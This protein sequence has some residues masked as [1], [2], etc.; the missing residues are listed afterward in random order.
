[1]LPYTCNVSNCQ[2]CSSSNPLICTQ[3]AS[4]YYLADSSNLTCSQIQCLDTQYYDSSTL[5]CTCPYGTFLINNKCVYCSIEKCVACNSGGCTDCKT[6]YYVDQGGCTRCSSNCFNCTSGSSC[7]ECDYGYSLQ[8]SGACKK[9]DDRY[10]STIVG[11]SSAKAICSGGC[12]EC[13]YFQG[14]IYCTVA[15]DGYAIDP[16]GT[17]IKCSD[18]CLTCANTDYTICTSCYGSSVLISGICA[19]CTDPYALTCPSNIKYSTSCLIGYS[20]INGVCRKCATNCQSCGQAGAGKCDDGGCGSGFVKIETT[21]NCTKC[22]SSC[23]TCSTNNP[24]TCLTC[25]NSNFLSNTSSCVS[26]PSAC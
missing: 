17:V 26:C 9:A 25:G 12:S 19:G 1:M 7:L 21:S 22:F 10:S 8:T 13:T 6:N 24:S 20:A 18:S 14:I 5:S 3:C 16:T 4:A 11:N 15:K 23:S 2:L